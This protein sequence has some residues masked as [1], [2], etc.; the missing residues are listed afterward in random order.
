LWDL[1]QVRLYMTDPGIRDQVQRRV[2]AAVRAETR[3][4]VGHSL[5][6]VVAYE[7]LCAYPGWPVTTLVTLGSPLGIRNLIFDRLRPAPTA[8]TR[9]LRGAWPGRVEMW[10]NIADSRDVVA[11]VKDLRPLFG[12]QVSSWLVS[13]CASAHAVQPYLTAPETGAA[14]AAGL[15]APERP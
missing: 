10:A 5:G 6:S 8:E 14:I 4:V 9:G 7:A 12:V 3:V 1:R 15:R 2:A 13:N 11:L